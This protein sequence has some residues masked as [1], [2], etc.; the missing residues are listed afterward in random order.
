MTLPHD[1]W[2]AQANAALF[3]HWDHASQSGTEIGWPLV[4]GLAHLPSP[5][6]RTA[7]EYHATADTFDPKRW[8]PQ[9]LV[10]IAKQIGAEYAIFTTRHH[11]G[12]STWPSK[13]GDFSIASSPFGQRGG[14]L[15]RDFTD[16]FRAAGIRIGL[17]YSLSDWHHPDYLRWTDDQRPYNYRPRMGTP[18]QWQRY[19]QYLKD[20]FTELLTQYGDV[21]LL[22]FD[23]DWERTRDE[24]DSD[25]LVA[26]IKRLAPNV[27]MNN[28]MPGHG[29]YETPEQHLP[30]HPPEGP[31]E[32]SVTINDTWA[33]VP[34]DKNFKSPFDLVRALIRIRAGG[35]IF[36]LNVGPT[37][38]GDIVPEERGRIDELAEWIAV[39]GESVFDCDPG[40]T[41][42][43][44]AG[45]STRK[46]DV[47]YLHL[48]AWP[49]E[50]LIVSGLPVRR[51]K[52][53]TM[54]ETGEELSYRT[55]VSPLSIDEADPE[56]ELT[57][58]MPAERP[59]SL[60]PVIKLE[61]DNFAEH[62]EALGAAPSR[63]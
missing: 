49:T 10:D 61:I 15:V 56:G 62:P 1:H 35:G 39:N 48:L 50:S 13:T 40:L 59:T 2:F 6:P 24:W 7:D 11:G 51:V 19:R 41:L 53:I 26:H 28:R 17:Y 54:L 46:G 23:G 34:E 16:A 27:I 57:I 25:D 58:T 60:A 22:W 36:L 52:S 37:G 21:D 45:P 32:C 30:V 9:T 3:I 4:G 12:W 20:Q 33:Y 63:L 8:D 5:T 43:Q 44:F 47:V 18:E 38:D 14:D 42:H 31:W 29:D 55:Q